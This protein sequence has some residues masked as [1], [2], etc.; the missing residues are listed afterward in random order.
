MLSNAPGDIATMQQPQ[1]QLAHEEP[2]QQQMQMHHQ[3][4]L[5]Q[6][7]QQQPQPGERC[8]LAPAAM[9]DLNNST[10]GLTPAEALSRSNPLAIPPV[11]AQFSA[12][13]ALPVLPLSLPLS[14]LPLPAISTKDLEF[15]MKLQIE[16]QR[17]CMQLHH[18]NVACEAVG[19]V[20]EER[21]QAAVSAHDQ[22]A[23][24]SQQLAAEA[25]AMADRYRLMDMLKGLHAGPVTGR[26]A[27][28]SGGQVVSR[29]EV[30][31]EQPQPQQGPRQPAEQ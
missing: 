30:M 4:A 9:S 15:L 21:R 22:A 12:P 28:V 1:P 20:V 19:A 24:A 6:Q 7:Q 25:R 10:S 2:V 3:S 8:Q 27:L 16:F 29:P 18:A 13:M 14:A 11:A 26:A 31:V 23:V 5:G 17:A